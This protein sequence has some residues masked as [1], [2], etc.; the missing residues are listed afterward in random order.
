MVGSQEHPGQESGNCEH[1]SEGICQNV[2]VGGPK[3]RIVPAMSAPMVVFVMIGAV[4]MRSL[5]SMIGSS[6]AAGL[7]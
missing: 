4:P 1:R 6:M 3:V 2:D 5:V 7:V